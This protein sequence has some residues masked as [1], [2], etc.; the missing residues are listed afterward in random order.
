MEFELSERRFELEED[1]C[2]FSPLLEHDV[3]CLC[4]DIPTHFVAVVGDE[5]GS[6]LS[7]STNSCRPY[8]LIAR[9]KVW[10]GGRNCFIII[11]FFKLVNIVNCNCRSTTYFVALVGSIYLWYLK[12]P[13]DD[14]EY[15]P[16]CGLVRLDL[17][18]LWIW[19][20][21]IFTMSLVGWGKGQT[22]SEQLWSFHAVVLNLWRVLCTLTFCQ[23]TKQQSS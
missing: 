15:C 7:I 1:S 13:E 23:V 21:A 2:A 14:F 10:V 19:V 4:H 11:L 6:V 3:N 17:K 20:L 9:W 18:W 16:K 5:W 22:S 12:V 8:E